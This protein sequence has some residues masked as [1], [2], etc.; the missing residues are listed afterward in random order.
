[1]NLG[2]GIRLFVGLMGSGKSF[3]MTKL[4][5]EFITNPSVRRPVYTNLPLKMRVAR[6][7]LRDRYGA[8]VAGLLRPLSKEQFE[9][10]TERLALRSAFVAERRTL[11]DRQGVALSWNRVDAEWLAEHGQ[12]DPD[13]NNPDSNWI[14]DGALIVIDEVQEWYGMRDQKSENASV[15]AYLTMHRHSGHE[16]WLATQKAMNVSISFRRLCD[17]WTFVHNKRD[18]RLAWGIRFKHIAAFAPTWGT[19][20]GYASYRAIDVKEGGEPSPLC[21]P[22]ENFTVRPLSR[23]N[24]HV[25]RLYE[26]RSR[27]GSMHR[28]RGMIE[29]ERVRAG[30]APDGLTPRERAKKEKE[31]RRSKSGLWRLASGVTRRVLVSI[32]VL[33][34]VGGAFRVGRW[35]ENRKH[36][37]SVSSVAPGATPAE[38]LGPSWPADFGGGLKGFGSDFV[39]LGSGKVGIGERCGDAELLRVERRGRISIWL[40]DD[41]VWL[42]NGGDAQPT[43]L[44]NLIEVRAASALA[45]DGNSSER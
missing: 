36:D 10:Y 12:D 4:V 8:E 35:A 34:L 31:M 24:R 20:F 1:M 43:I 22:F 7:W 21:Q 37:E 15:L 5:L 28:L 41:D 39:R 16:I 11:A 45:I 25:F 42:W 40:L 38:P 17:R 23:R 3:V 18:D 30:L 19:L 6:K 14:A 9:R 27:I 2:H 13:T 29:R 26:S 32:V 33:L 44:G